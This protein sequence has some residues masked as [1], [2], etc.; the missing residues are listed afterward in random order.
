MTECNFYYLTVDPYIDLWTLKMVKLYAFGS[1]KVISLVQMRSELQMIG[2][3]KNMKN[4]PLL[5]PRRY[6]RRSLKSYCSIQDLSPK[7]N[8]K[9][10]T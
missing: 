5:G 9:Y 7:I 1:G 8:E 4:G 2:W 10:S 3:L 6:G